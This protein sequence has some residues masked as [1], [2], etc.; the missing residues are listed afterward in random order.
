MEC[1]EPFGTRASIERVVA[2]LQDRHWM[3]SGAAQSRTRVLMMCA[4]CRVQAAAN[5]SFDPHAA[6]QRPRV[7]TSEDYLAERVAKDN[8][9]AR[10]EDALDTLP[11]S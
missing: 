2:K 9:A 5:E 6:P 4:D 11:N 8:G 7:R 3:F 1:G 10:P